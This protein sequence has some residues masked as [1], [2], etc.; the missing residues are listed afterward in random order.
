MTART[1]RFITLEGIDGAGKSTHVPWLAER[2]R[3]AGHAIVTT[4]EPG[5]TPF[6][7]ALRTLLLRE[8][9]SHDSEALL[10]FAAR[11]DHLDRVIRPALARGEWV[12]CDRFTDATYA[13]QGGGHGVSLD[14]IGQLEAWIHGDCQPDLTLLFD[15]PAVVSRARLDRAQAEGRSLD[16]FEREAGAFFER[17]RDAYLERA[18]RDPRRFRI[19]DS[20][21]PLAEVRRDLEANVAAL[22]A[23]DD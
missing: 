7:E 19:I 16:K 18:N 4:R 3:A 14:R 15:I 20:T 12:L 22:D 1:G 17:V 11:R 9:M 23:R 2:V 8:P 5:G 10:M 13:Y 6:G 21:R